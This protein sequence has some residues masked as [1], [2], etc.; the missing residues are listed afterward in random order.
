MH[1]EETKKI[2]LYLAA[3]YPGQKEKLW[4]NEYEMLALVGV[5]HDM[6]YVFPADVAM[7]AVKNY[8]R[9]GNQFF[10]SAGSIVGLCDDE[11]QHYLNQK[12]ATNIM[13]NKDAAT[14]L[15]HKPL[16][17]F[18]DDYVKKSVN[19][20]RRVCDGDIKFQSAEWDKEYNSIFHPHL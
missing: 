6:L 16:N 15:F 1:I 4:K 17:S 13:A 20:I 2:M 11:W 14:L 7:Q 12:H 9:Q 3:A 19:L 5:W 18:A 10:P 8:I